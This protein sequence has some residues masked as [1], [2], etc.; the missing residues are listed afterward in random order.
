MLIAVA[1]HAAGGEDSGDKLLASAWSIVQETG[2]NFNG[3]WILGA[4]TWVARD[5]ARRRQ[6]LIDGEALLASG[7]LSHNHFHFYQYAI[8]FALELRQ[9][10][11]AQRY[12][13]ALESYTASEP[14]TWTDLVSARA[15]VLSRFGRG[16]RK[17]SLMH[18]AAAL[19]G[20]LKDMG[21]APAARAL[22]EALCAD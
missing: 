5:E 17:D 10:D 3:P 1:R 20:S 18:E 9:W 8:D 7:C 4:M 11:E 22:E 15:R 19:A 2:P 14:L 16:E 6:A 21:L 13:T 12:A